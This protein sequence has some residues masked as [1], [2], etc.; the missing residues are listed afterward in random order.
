MAL[1]FH[2]HI[3]VKIWVNS[4]EK[5][6]NGFYKKKTTNMAHGITKG[7]MIHLCEC[8]FIKLSTFIGQ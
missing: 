7:Y 6:E 2:Q 4:L 1:N 8:D 5:K 3:T